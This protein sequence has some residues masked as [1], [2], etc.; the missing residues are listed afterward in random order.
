MRRLSHSHTLDIPL[1]NNW[2]FQKSKTEPEFPQPSQPVR[3]R[4][5]AEQ[6]QVDEDARRKAMKDLVG[7]WNDRLQL[8][9]LITTSRVQS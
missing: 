9:S 7:S 1:A 2:K 5:Q 6:D 4:T 8:I 3:K